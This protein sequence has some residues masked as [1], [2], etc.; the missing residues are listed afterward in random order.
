[1]DRDVEQLYRS[2]YRS[3]LRT[4]VLLTPSVEDA[5]DVV[6][7]AFARALARWSS[8]RALDEPH[9]WVRR[10]AVNAA[11]DVGRRTTS[12]R[13]LLRR[14]A[15]EPAQVAGPV[16][17]RVGRRPGAA[18]ADGPAAPGGGP[19]PP[20]GPGRRGDRRRDRTAGRHGQDRPPPGPSR[21]GPAPAAR[22]GRPRCLTSCQSCSTLL[23][24]TSSRASRC[25]P[26][27]RVPPGVRLDPA[28]LA[29]V[30][31]CLRQ[32]GVSVTEHPQPGGAPAYSYAY[33]SLG[34]EAG[35]RLTERC[36][37]D[38]VGR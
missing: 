26:S 35:Q 30:A 32:R 33:G 17:D 16:G 28:V 8:V 23:R 25:P 11:L 37:D 5:H 21:A 3:V 38:A 15:A 6:Q 18:A 4:V 13:R 36:E 20:A 22:R 2:T 29:R 1:M 27:G 24:T 10:V 19:A 7:E 14:L 31:A 12:R 34:A 9:E